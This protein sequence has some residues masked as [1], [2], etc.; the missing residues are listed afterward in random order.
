MYVVMFLVMSILCMYVNTAY[1]LHCSQVSEFARHLRPWSAF[2]PHHGAVVKN[3]GVSSP[4]C[5]LSQGRCMHTLGRFT[6][7]M[8][9]LL[10][11]SHKKCDR[12]WM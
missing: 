11:E 8:G 1:L 2:C 3:D 5:A 9:E 4:P 10:G 12:N 6:F 7:P